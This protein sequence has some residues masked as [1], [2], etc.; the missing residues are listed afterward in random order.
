MW[1]RFKKAMK[2]VWRAVKAVVRVVVRVVVEVVNRRWFGLPDLLLGFIAWPPK[3]LRLHVFILWNEPPGGGDP[4]PPI[5]QVAQAAIDRTKRLYKDKFNVNLRA[6]SKSFIETLSGPFPDA[7]LD[8]ECGF[9]QE[10]GEAGEFFAGHLAGWNAIPVSLTFPITVFVVRD[11]K[12]GSLGCSMFVAGDY[13]VIDREGLADNLALAHEL[14]HACGLWHSK[15]SSNLMYFQ[16]PAGEN[17]KWFQKN[18]LRSSRH[19]QYW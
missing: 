18:L 9:G 5:E 11:L 13:I 16:S 4:Q 10:F 14:G 2:K 8:F 19:V 7:V 1:K 12:G 15:T 17:V 6:Y 3:R